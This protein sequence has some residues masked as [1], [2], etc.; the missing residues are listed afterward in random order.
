[1]ESRMIAAI[2]YMLEINQRELADLLGLSSESTVSRWIAGTSRPSRANT[3]KLHEILGSDNIR[4]MQQL[5]H[6][7]ELYE[8]QKDMRNRIERF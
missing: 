7:R 5:V 6:N 4:I 1:M 3:R 8:V 2:L